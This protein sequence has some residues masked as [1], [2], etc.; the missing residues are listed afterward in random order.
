MIQ[1]RTLLA[2]L[3]LAVVVAAC[4]STFF[5]VNP[6][7]SWGRSADGKY[8]GP[9]SSW[10]DEGRQHMQAS[11]TYKEDRQFG[12]WTYWNEKGN[13]EWEG[14]FADER[15]QGQHTYWY[16][17]GQMRAQG[18]FDRGLETGRWT[19]W[20][21]QGV[22]YREGDFVKG[23]RSGA[24]TYYYLGGEKLAEG[25]FKDERKTGVWEFWNEQGE[26]SHKQ[27][28]DDASTTAAPATPGKTGEPDARLLAE[29]DKKIKLPIRAQP[30]T[31]N[32]E[33]NAATIVG[34]YRD[35]AKKVALP[36]SGPYSKGKLPTRKRDNKRS[37]AL[38][39]KT[40]YGFDLTTGDGA[41]V[42]LA[43]Y[44]GRKVVL[45]VL[46]GMGGEVCVY[47]AGQTSA[48]ADRQDEFTALGADIVV[49][50]PGGE[51]RLDAFLEGYKK[52]RSKEGD[53]PFPV[54]CD[55]NTELVQKLDIQGNLALPT[56][57]ILDGTG[58]VR[59]AY[60]GL[61]KA[62]RPEI[63]ALLEALKDIK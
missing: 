26:S 37:D 25:T 49:V 36:A 42:D 15:L 27:F 1:R 7:K 24:W 46:R 9:G 33:E 28:Q 13:K 12:S 59:Y 51:D 18:E 47:C 5:R 23:R 4:Q 34:I 48:F 55:A 41:S 10:F 61:D 54:V 11:G 44:K 60:V 43:K 35:G 31:A 29:V 50:Y 21:P 38:I 63:P 16:D 32:E 17:S 53:P 40:I 39:G 30:W 8:E 22:K 57:M 3:L 6:L 62:D 52:L 56:T 19:Y 20:T 14:S 58:V 45:V 2:S